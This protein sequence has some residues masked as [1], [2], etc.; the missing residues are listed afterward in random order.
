MKKRK[1]GLYQLTETIEIYGKKHR[2][3]FYGKTIPEAKKKRDEFLRSRDPQEITF[4]D[5]FKLFKKI[6]EPRISEAAFNTKTERIKMF[7]AIFPVKLNA[8][9][10]QMIAVEINK[11]AVKNPKTHKPTAKRTL[12]RYL[13]AV[14]NVY[15]FAISER[16][17]QYNPTK[18]VRIPSNAPQTDREALLPL[19]Y[20]LILSHTENDYLAPQIMILCG[21]RRGELTALTYGD[22]SDVINVNK[23]YDFKSDTIKLPKTKSGIRQVPIPDKLKN[24]LLELKEKHNSTDYV[25]NN[26]GKQYTEASWLNLRKRLV[27]SLGFNFTW[28]Q[29]RHTY[30]TILYDS[31]V[32]VLSAQKFL[33]HSDVKVTLGIYT[34]LSEKRQEKSIENLNKFLA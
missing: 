1:D 13:A 20:N 27:K 29:L 31:G 23:S 8:V 34:S 12:T 7:S 18:Y 15:E 32:D 33:G 22:I 3:T 4:E 2:K 24:I 9:T 30:A 11:L 10:P 19:E 25:I 26:G 21:L 28:H 17:T 6:E 16:L 14:S 5:A